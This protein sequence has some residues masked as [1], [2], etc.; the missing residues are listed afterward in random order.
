MLVLA[1]M[2]TIRYDIEKVG[3]NSHIFVH[4]ECYRK[5]LDALTDHEKIPKIIQC[6]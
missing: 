3:S 2:L 5:K 1:I 6:Q 4:Q